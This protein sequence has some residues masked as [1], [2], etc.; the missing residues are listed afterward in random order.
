MGDDQSSD[1]VKRETYINLYLHVLLPLEA[2]GLGVFKSIPAALHK[3]E[4]VQF[5]FTIANVSCDFI[6]APGCA[7][8]DA[9]C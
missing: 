9:S 3:A 4:D 6:A 5:W 2:A 1:K 7:Y 8:W